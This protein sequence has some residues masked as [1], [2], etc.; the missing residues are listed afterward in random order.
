MRMEQNKHN[1]KV[2]NLKSSEICMEQ[3]RSPIRKYTSTHLVLLLQTVSIVNILFLHI[4]CIICFYDTRST[5]LLEFR[6]IRNAHSLQ[7][8]SDSQ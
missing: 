2:W 8:L 1:K 3:T 5:L 4:I 7:N 6:I